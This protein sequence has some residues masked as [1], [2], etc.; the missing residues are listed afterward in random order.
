MGYK[1]S[2]KI[3]FLIFSILL[4]LVIFGIFHIV[5][6]DYFEQLIT[7]S[8]S[9]SANIIRNQ[10]T[11]ND[12]LYGNE[13]SVDSLAEE[14]YL[15]TVV[16][17]NI[18]IS[19]IEKIQKRNPD[20]SLMANARILMLGDSHLMGPF[21][22]HLQ[23]FIHESGFFDILSIS[24]AGAGSATF[25]Y[26]LRNNCCGYAI[27]ESLHDEKIPSNQNIRYLEY[28]SGISGDIVGKKY[29][30][31]LSNVLLE[32][33]PDIIII[34]LGS[35]YSND[36]QGLINILKKNAPMAQIVWIGPM[37]RK[38]ISMRIKAIQQAVERNEIF[39]VRSDDVIG[40]DTISTGH[41]YGIEAKRWANTIFERIKPLLDRYADSQQNVNKNN[42][43]SLKHE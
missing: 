9:N 11:L 38:Q 12:T 1:K 13:M 43:D 37:K 8:K 39:F 22:E 28:N 25:V 32:I 17:S 33:E 3:W 5:N 4:S 21:G 35:N 40:S 41:F 42:T 14:K 19:S 26:P 27:R 15:A 20:D 31:R 36:H 16:K 6:S 7:E 34:A 18:T 10:G 2:K 23:R 29:N 24:I 30:G